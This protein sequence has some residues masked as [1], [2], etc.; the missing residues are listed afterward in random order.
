MLNLKPSHKKI[1][2]L[3]FAAYFVCSVFAVA[4]DLDRATPSKTCAICFMNSSLSSAVGQAFVVAEIDLKQEYTHI[5]EK[6]A[7]VNTSVSYSGISYRGPPPQIV[8]FL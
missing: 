4:F 2:L 6:I 5:F 8:S 7:F 3:F 1:L